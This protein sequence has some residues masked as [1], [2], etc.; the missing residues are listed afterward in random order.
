SWTGHD[1]VP[2]RQSGAGSHVL[3]GDAR[4]VL[5]GRLAD[6]DDLVAGLDGASG[7]A[8]ARAGTDVV[9]WGPR[10]CTRLREVPG[11]LHQELRE[12]RLLRHCLRIT[13]EALAPTHVAELEGVVA[14]STDRSERPV[15][16]ESD[17]LGVVGVHVLP[18]Q[19]VEVPDLVAEE[20]PE[21]A[22]EEGVVD[23]VDG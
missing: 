21:L 4:D 8:G 3:A 6:P 1:T 16:V 15:R 10:R 11:A 2:A 19:P 7:E 22:Q 14:D 18:E 12:E 9:R 17:L 13:V 23:P 5:D 20:V